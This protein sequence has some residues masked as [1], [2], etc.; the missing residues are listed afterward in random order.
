MVVAGG[1]SFLI[2]YFLSKLFRKMHRLSLVELF[3][4]IL[5]LITAINIPGALLLKYIRSGYN[6]SLI[7][8]FG[9]WCS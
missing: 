8:K 1:G 7:L 2:S 9:R 6:S 5:M 4:F 3:L